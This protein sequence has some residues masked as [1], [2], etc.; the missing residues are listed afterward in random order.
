MA[1]WV[2][3][4][5]A[6]NAIG[7]VQRRFVESKKQVEKM[8]NKLRKREASVVLAY[9]SSRSGAFAAIYCAKDVFA[10]KE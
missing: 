6:S 3:K 10:V 9:V 1:E 5:F 8:R 2:K 7:S 4:T